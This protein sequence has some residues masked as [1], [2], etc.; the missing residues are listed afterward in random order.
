MLVLAIAILVMEHVG[1]GVRLVAAYSQRQADI[2]EIFCDV[3]VE[4]FGFFQ[5]AVHA[6]GQLLSLGTNFGRRHA[7]V[8]FEAGVPAADLLPAFEGR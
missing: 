2:A 1:S 5:V 8:L 7:T 3:I 4:R 6:P